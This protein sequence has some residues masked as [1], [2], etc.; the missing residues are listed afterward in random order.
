[1]ELQRS[2]S[3]FPKHHWVSSQPIRFQFQPSILFLNLVPCVSVRVPQEN[4]SL[5]KGSNDKV[6]IKRW[7]TKV[8]ASYENKLRGVTHPETSTGNLLRERHY[9][10][11]GW[12]DSGGKYQRYCFCQSSVRVGAKV[13]RTPSSRYSVIGSG[14]CQNWDIVSSFF[15][16]PTDVSPCLDPSQSRPTAGPKWVLPKESASR[17][18]ECRPDLRVRAERWQKGTL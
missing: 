3:I 1:M 10:R 15:W 5:P 9:N 18:Q 13:K 2:E 7:F 12:R 17:D 6:L 8:W 11:Q 16:S 4:R 14:Y